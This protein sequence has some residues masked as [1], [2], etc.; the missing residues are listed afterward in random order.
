MLSDWAKAS[1]AGRPQKGLGRAGVMAE[2]FEISRPHAKLD[3]DAV[4]RH[5]GNSGTTFCNRAAV[6][7]M[8]N[9]LLR[10]NN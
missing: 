5:S 1:R 2:Q 10:Q 4:A 9:T 6:K 8:N 7:N 3:E